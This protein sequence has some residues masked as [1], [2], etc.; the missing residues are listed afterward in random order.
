MDGLLNRVKRP[1]LTRLAVFGLGLLIAVLPS[2][3]GSA[4]IKITPPRVVP[5]EAQIQS[6]ESHLAGGV[7]HWINEAPFPIPAGLTIVHRD[8]ALKSN[9]LVSYLEW[10]RDQDPAFFDRRHPNVGAILAQD[11]TTTTTSTAPNST[12]TT[13]AV[14]SATMQAAQMLTPP[15]NVASGGSSGSAGQGVAEAQILGAPTPVPEPSSVATALILF[16]AAAWW[17]RRRSR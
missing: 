5:T 7:D 3:A 13:S 11:T 9:M 15:S 1:R 10:R 2:S 4:T 14:S 6:L 8:G 17:R 12:T 16:G